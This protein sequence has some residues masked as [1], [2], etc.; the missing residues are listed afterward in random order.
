M[1]E[2]GNKIISTDKHSKNK[3]GIIWKI[4]DESVHVKFGSDIENV[5]FQ[6]F[7]FNPTHHIQSNI[8][9]LKLYNK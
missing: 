7:F 4:T 6:K 9:D 3:I 8:L 2:V 5:T 1:W